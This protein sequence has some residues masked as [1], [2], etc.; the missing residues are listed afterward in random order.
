MWIFYTYTFYSFYRTYPS[1]HKCNISKYL[2]SPG[3]TTENLGIG[4]PG[5]IEKSQREL[6]AAFRNRFFELIRILG[7]KGKRR[8]FE[9]FFHVQKKFDFFKKSFRKASFLPQFLFQ[10][11]FEHI[12]VFVSNKI[13]RHYENLLS[14]ISNWQLIMVLC[15]CNW[16]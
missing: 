13:Q 6:K 2:N 1:V 14:F 7:G 10:D 5:R 11:W 8:F 16:C 15:C 12:I 3:K 4:T 9:S